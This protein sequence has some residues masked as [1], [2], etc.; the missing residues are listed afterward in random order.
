MLDVWARAN[1][2][3]DRAPGWSVDER[4]RRL[5]PLGEFKLLRASA[6]SRHAERKKLVNEFLASSDGSF[7]TVYKAL[8]AAAQD[9]KS[10][11]DLKKADVLRHITRIRDLD[12]KS[13]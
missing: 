6:M 7:S 1:Q 4:V 13:A 3:E 8:N 12:K 9:N 5:I 10:A 11:S 2:I